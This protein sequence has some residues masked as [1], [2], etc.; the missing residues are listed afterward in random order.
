MPVNDTLLH[1]ILQKQK[2]LS[3]TDIK[4]AETVASHLGVTLS[5]VLVG[6]NFLTD[7]QLG[8]ALAR[9]YRSEFVNLSTTH[10]P[11]HVLA[12]IPEEV[13][14]S[15]LVIAFARDENEI[16]VAL[17]DPKDLS[18]IEYIKKTIGGGVHIVPYL[19]TVSGLRT[20]LKHYQKKKRGEMDLPIEASITTDISVIG[21]VEEILETAVKSEASDIHI[22]PLADQLLVRLR[23]DG[24]LRDIKVLSIDLHPEI[25]SRLKVLATLKLDEQRLPQDGNFSFVP[26]NGTRISLRV[27][28]IPTVYGEK[29]VLRILTD[30]VKK[31]TLEELGLGD[32]DQRI[33]ESV[34]QRTHGMFLVT[35]PTGSG[36]TTTLYTILSILNKP[37]LNIITIE[38]PVEN[39]IRRVNQIQVNAAIDLT[40]ANGLRSILRQDPDI[41]MV[42]EIRDHETAVISVNAAMTGHLVFSTVHANSAAGAVPRMIDLGVE[43]FLLASTINLVIAQRLVRVLC[44][45]C[46]RETPISP[47]IADRLAKAG[48]A[49]R[50]HVRKLLKTNYEPKGCANCSF[51]GFKGRAGIFEVILIDDELKRMIVNKASSSEINAY[52]RSRGTTSMF[53][54][55]MRKVSEGTTTIEEVLR[56]ISQ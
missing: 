22:E 29:V 52:A 15:R 1:T 54:D 7:E 47:I 49:L 19:A 56:V 30:A 10:I 11:A 27:S 2:L 32:E 9:Y 44:P 43:P 18:L 55:G 4:R 16:S 51:S 21:L 20:A 14:E 24:V 17:T 25:I 23:L 35:G 50:P 39:R 3:L 48:D 53:E 36:K 42:G 12:L 8:L 38:D 34:L 5:E 45:H 40:F 41:I 46:L 13:A 31:F 26:K 33:V 28:T 6:R 37:D